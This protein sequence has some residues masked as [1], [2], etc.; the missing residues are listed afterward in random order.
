MRK[1][2]WTRLRDFFSTPR[3]KMTFKDLETSGDPEYTVS[4]NNKFN[5]AVVH[6]LKDIPAQY[7]EEWR[8]AEAYSTEE[9]RRMLLK[10]KQDEKRNEAS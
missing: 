5:E 10:K 6:Q 3:K 1:N 4:W 2:L 7:K 8:K 9:F